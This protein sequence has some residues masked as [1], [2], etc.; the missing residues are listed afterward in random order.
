[1]LWEKSF[2][3][4]GRGAFLAL[5][6]PSFLTFC[7]IFVYFGSFFDLGKHFDYVKVSLLAHF[8]VQAGVAFV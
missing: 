5:G 3:G 4:P 8:F 1:M 6:P 2:L 7:I